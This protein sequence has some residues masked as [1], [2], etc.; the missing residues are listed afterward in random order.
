MMKKQNKILIANR[1]EIALRVIRACKEL[2][3]PCV[4]VYSKADQDSLHVKFADEAICIGEGRSAESYLNIKNVISAAIATGCNSIHPG[5]GFLAENEKFIEL[6]ERCGLTFIGPR[7]EV[8]RKFGDKALAR[9][10]AKEAGIPIVEVSEGIVRDL[11]EAKLVAARIGFP[12]M[13]K[14]TAGGGGKGIS[15]VR[16]C[17]E[18]VKNFELTRMEAEANFGNPDVYLEKFIEKPRH[19]EIQFLAD[20]FGNVVYF[21]ERDCSVQRRN[22]KII[23]ESPSPFINE[24]LRRTLGEAAVRL[25]KATGYANAGTV[26]FIVDGE[27]RFYFLEVNA[28]I[29]VEHPVTEELTGIDLV[30]E[31]IRIA[32]N[33][34][35]SLKQEDIRIPGHALECRITAEDP[36]TF[37]PC[38][39]PVKNL[40]LPG[41]PGVRIDTHLYNGYEVPPLYDSLLA[42]LVVFAPTRKEA[43]RKMRVALEQFII[44]GVKNNIDILYLILHNTNFVR[45]IYD[46][47]FMKSFMEI[48]KGEL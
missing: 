26:E 13:I 39:G 29:Q 14:A 32:Y 28:R 35:L 24:D 22:Q 10:I 38:P 6:L 8:V 21:P 5:Y 48:L 37:Q 42:K 2:G 47:G 12:L 11:E 17:D 44:D 36:L 15:V 25:V 34:E 19:I 20:C 27:G 7:S 30:K 46:T 45:G 16:D 31:Q 23:E 40:V 41:G 18:L 4:A 33:D 43:I 9:R 3:I 1:G